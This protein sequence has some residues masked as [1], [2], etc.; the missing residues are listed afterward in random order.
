ME[1]L[2]SAPGQYGKDHPIGGVVADYYDVA[3]F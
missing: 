3:L 1:Q 2:F